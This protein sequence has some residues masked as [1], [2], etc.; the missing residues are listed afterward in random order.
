MSAKTNGF[1]QGT[2]LK[3]AYSMLGLTSSVVLTRI[4]LNI[5]KPRRLTASDYFV[6]IAFVFHVT[7]CTL[8]VA[9]SPYMQRVYAVSN[10][11]TEPYPELLHD[12]ILM[13]KMVFIA[14]CMFWAVLWSI[15]L[16]LLL[17]YRR[18]LVGISQRYTVVWWCIAG[19]C[20]VTF[21]GNYFFYFQ[22]CGTIPGFW[23]GGC[24][25]KGPHNTQLISLYYSFSADTS[26][27]VMIMAL[28]I[29]L[30]WN[31][32]MPR[33]KKVS[34]LCLFATGVICILFACLRVTQVAINAAKPEAIGQPLDPTWLAIWGMVEC[35]IAV[36][37][38]C[39]PA[40]AVLVKALRPK[41]SYDSRGYRRQTNSNSDKKRVSKLELNTIGCKRDLDKG[42]GLDT[43][44][45]HWADVHS[46][47]EELR[48]KHDGILV[49]TTVIH[50]QD[51]IDA[52]ERA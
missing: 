52:F 7:K 33:S 43:T 49:S 39:C 50:E 24:T 21:A 10:G 35:S 12:R 18:L 31:L 48:A 37:I 41:N 32:Q 42:L 20:L 17:L 46:S 30:T 29:W 40:F 13:A 15:K 2:V 23:T 8:Y 27:N 25:G 11:E 19:I 16:S 5:L 14:F 26:T 9:L 22:S 28:P 34:I 51:S 4:V 47:Q 6:F 45:L 44:D 38:G 36:I 1:A 3:V